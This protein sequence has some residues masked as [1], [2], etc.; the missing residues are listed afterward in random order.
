MSALIK[1]LEALFA[2][3]EQRVLAA[4]VVRATAGPAAG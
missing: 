3:S 2:N 1:E 4:F